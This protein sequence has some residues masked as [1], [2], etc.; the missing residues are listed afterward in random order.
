[1]SNDV[2]KIALS[3]E[4]VALVCKALDIPNKN[5]AR[6]QIDCRPDKAACV[7]I[8]RYIEVGEAEVMMQ[9][10]FRD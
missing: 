10:I 1:M 8:E 6:L 2:R 7:Y 9:G 3:R 5:I 4:V